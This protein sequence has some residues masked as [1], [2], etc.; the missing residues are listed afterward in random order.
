VH[1][2]RSRDYVLELMDGNVERFIQAL[3]RHSYY[4]TI[5][6]PVF[7]RTP[8]GITISRPEGAERVYYTLDG[9]DPRDPTAY[10]FSEAV[11]TVPFSSN[12]KGRS[13]RGKEW[14]ALNEFGIWGQE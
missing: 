9:S 11:S 14:S 10:S 12:L 1:W 2:K 4:P 5:D 7:E 13:R 6:P 3:R 8:D